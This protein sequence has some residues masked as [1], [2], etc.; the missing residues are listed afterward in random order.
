MKAVEE[1][2]TSRSG[3]I[4]DLCCGTGDLTV[5]ISLLSTDNEEITGLDY[6]RL[7]LDIAGSKARLL[8]NKPG[9]V[10]GDVSELPFKNGCFDCIGISFAFRNL[11]YRNPNIKNHLSEILRVL[12]PGGRFII[13]E[14]SQPESQLIQ[15]LFHLY[16]RLF[17]SRIGT[18]I[19]GN[20]GAYRYLAESAS[21]F[22]TPT[23]LKELLIKAGFKKVAYRPF[24]FG[25]VGIHVAT[26]H[27]PRV[28]SG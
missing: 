5:N 2:L 14:S 9:F 4:L 18:M 24:L 15:K 3:K 12:K 19:S 11:T 22:Y 20:S 28:V 1:C 26:S 23:E 6:S 7:M 17:V 16:L 8:D 13:V 27:E 25:A 10:T 21:R